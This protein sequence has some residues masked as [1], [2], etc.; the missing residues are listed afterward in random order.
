MNWIV[1]KNNLNGKG[2]K[3]IVN[4]PEVAR[5]VLPGQYIRLT[6]DKDEQAVLLTVAEADPLKGNLT[7]F[8]RNGFPFAGKLNQKMVG[9][10]VYRIEGPFGYPL[11]FENE[12]NLLCLIDCQALEL[13]YPWLAGMKNQGKQAQIIIIDHFDQGSC[14]I[15]EL[16]NI[17]KNISILTYNKAVNQQATLVNRLKDLAGNYMFDRLMVLGNANLIKEVYLYS[18]VRKIKTSAYLLSDKKDSNGHAQ[19][20][21]VEI[22]TQ[23]K[24]ICVDG[25]D[26]N[27]HYLNFD[28]MVHHHLFEEITE[29]AETISEMKNLKTQLIG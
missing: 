22:C 8:I 17:T 14:L 15:D 26:F 21:R 28:S 12:E 4:A 20:F 24:M 6:I 5:I 16:K 23:S 7:V 9:E 13:F 11:A 2:C 29:Q 3:V 10:E 27:A 25:I 1:A 18:L 19:L